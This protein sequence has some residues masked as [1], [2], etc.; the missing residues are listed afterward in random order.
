MITMSHVQTTFLPLVAILSH[1]CW[2]NKGIASVVHWKFRLHVAS[3]SK[4]DFVCKKNYKLAHA[5]VQCKNIFLIVSWKE[6]REMTFLSFSSLCALCS[7]SKWFFI[8]W[9][10]AEG[11]IY[12]FY[13]DASSIFFFI[14]LLMSGTGM[15][16]FATVVLHIFIVHESVCVPEVAC[17]PSSFLRNFAVHVVFPLLHLQLKKQSPLE[18]RF[19]CVCG[20]P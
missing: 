6:P 5:H 7:L 9:K 4:N 2:N 18:H 20:C 8:N 14:S 17:V 11:L 13:N 15:S 1:T 16:L 3:T 10:T 19:L 12:K